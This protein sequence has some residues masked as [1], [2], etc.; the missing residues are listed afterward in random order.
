MASATQKAEFTIPFYLWDHEVLI[1]WWQIEHPAGRWPSS[2]RVIT[3]QMPQL[4][5]QGAPPHKPRGSLLRG[6]GCEGPTSLWRGLRVE[7]YEWNPALV[8]KTLH[9]LRQCE[10]E[11]TQVE[12][13]IQCP[14][15][16]YTPCTEWGFA[17]PRLGGNEP[18]TMQLDG[19]LNGGHWC[20]TGG[21]VCV[22]LAA[23]P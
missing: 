18:A 4:C 5:F 16:P 12:E 3:K 6:V 14:P 11:D 13:A 15:R 2:R 1:N 7:D 8:N 22:L 10:D 21:S 20:H 17:P 23:Q 9:I 19:C